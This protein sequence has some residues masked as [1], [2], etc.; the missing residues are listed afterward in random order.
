M[1]SRRNNQLRS[2]GIGFALRLPV[3]DLGSVGCRFVRIVVDP[4]VGEEVCLAFLDEPA[5]APRYNLAGPLGLTANAGLVRTP[6]GMIGAIIWHVGANSPV[7]CFVEQ[8]LNMASPG[9]MRL[10]QEAAG[11]SH[12]KFI[13]LDNRTSDV[14]TLIDFENG[15]K[16]DALVLAMAEH[17]ADAAS[18]AFDQAV[19]YAKRNADLIGKIRA[20]L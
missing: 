8:F 2:D 4:D 12:L 16:L 20:Q 19:Q 17:A 11:Q 9:T 13:V 5:D 3:E 15:F 14:T 1:T 10:L 18:D 6:H 7:E